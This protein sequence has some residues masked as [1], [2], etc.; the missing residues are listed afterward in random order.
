MEYGVRSKTFLTA[1]SV[2]HT[3]FFLKKMPLPI[4]GLG[5]PK[6]L[7]KPWLAGAIWVLAGIVYS[8][9]INYSAE[10]SVPSPVCLKEDDVVTH[11]HYTKFKIK[12]PRLHRA[13]GGFYK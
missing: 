5:L 10:Q 11:L 12:A 1:Y 4:T 8:V 7:A 9:G 6:P 13:T 2:L 3:P